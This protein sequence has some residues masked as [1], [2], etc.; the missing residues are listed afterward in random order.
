VRYFGDGGDADPLVARL[1]ARL[2]LLHRLRLEMEAGHSFDA[3]CQTL[4]VRLPPE[5]R[6]ALAKAAERW[7]SE[8]IAVRLPNIRAMSAKV[9]ATPGMAE[10]L[11]SRAIWAL[12]SGGRRARG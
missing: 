3:A 9:R 4:F 6:R 8:T 12:A 1:V 11:A 5:A 7:T 10:V 2:T